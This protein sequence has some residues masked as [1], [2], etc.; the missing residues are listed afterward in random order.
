MFYLLCIPLA[1]RRTDPG[2]P[3]ERSVSISNRGIVVMRCGFHGFINDVPL[4][5][6]LHMTMVRIQP[7]YFL[8]LGFVLWGVHEFDCLAFTFTFGLGLGRHVGFGDGVFSWLL[9][10]GLG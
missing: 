5:V 4:D 9:L 3:R 6:T 1:L 8:L 10:S 2:L 7:V